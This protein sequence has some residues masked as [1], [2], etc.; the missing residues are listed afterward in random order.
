MIIYLAIY[1]SQ[2]SFCF[3]K[4]FAVYKIKARVNLYFYLFHRDAKFSLVYVVE[5][6]I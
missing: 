6:H 5:G 2:I 4:T 1:A 3:G